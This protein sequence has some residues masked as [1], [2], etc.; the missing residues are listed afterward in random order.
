MKD[1]VKKWWFWGIII[2]LISCILI[3]VLGYSN[4]EFNNYKKESITILNQYKDGKLTRKEA[5]EKID[6]ISDKLK[7]ERKINDDTNIFLLE[8]K[9]SSI[10]YELFNQELSNTEIDTYIQEIKRLD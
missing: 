6:A 4:T 8:V 10:T 2:I 9:L 5:E 1:L 3:Y 7:N